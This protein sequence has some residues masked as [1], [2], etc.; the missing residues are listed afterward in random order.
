M[1]NNHGYYLKKKLLTNKPV[2]RVV[3]DHLASQEFYPKN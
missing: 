2:L 3:T 1:Y